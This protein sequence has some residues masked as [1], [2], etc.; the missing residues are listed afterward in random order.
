ML[1]AVKIMKKDIRIEPVD[2]QKYI[3]SSIAEI[4]CEADYENGKGK[5]GNGDQI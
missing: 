2:W 3:I 4:C 1:A 5:N